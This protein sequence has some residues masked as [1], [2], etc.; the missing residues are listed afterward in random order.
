MAIK[1]NKNF[2]T[3]I[4]NLNEK[5]LLYFTDWQNNLLTT[6]NHNQGLN[7]PITLGSQGSASITSLSDNDDGNRKRQ[8]RLLKNRFLKFCFKNNV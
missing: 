7:G 3:E 2:L 6:Y 5:F 4:Q 1:I 8:V